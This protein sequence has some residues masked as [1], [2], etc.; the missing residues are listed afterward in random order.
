MALILVRSFVALNLRLGILDFSLELLL[1]VVEF[2]LEGQKV[3]IQGDA[4]TQKRFIATRLVFLVDLAV[5]EELDLVLH[6][7]DLLVQVQDDV[8]VDGIR[9]PIFFLA[10]GQRL[11]LVGGL[12]QLGVTFEFLVDDRPSVP[13]I[14]V[15][16][17]RCKLHVSGC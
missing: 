1:L 10:L 5:L 3:L 13:F 11:D 4:V 9:L 17:A 12:L 7:G 2:V 8:F 6:R 16:V 14:N 15:K